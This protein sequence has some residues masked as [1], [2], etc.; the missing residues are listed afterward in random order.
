MQEQNRPADDTKQKPETVAAGSEQGA[1][2]KTEPL[3]PEDG[4]RD[5]KREGDMHNGELGAG[6][7]KEG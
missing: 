5:D 6:L 2:Q 1:K 3:G 7:K 4:G